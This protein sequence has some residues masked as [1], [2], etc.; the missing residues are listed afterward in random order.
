MDAVTKADRWLKPEEAAQLTGYAVKTLTG[1]RYEG[2]G[3]RY[4]KTSPARSGRVRYRES[5]VIAW[6][7]ARECGGEAA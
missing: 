6:M 3:P 4:T 1:W 2:R 7:K 5:D